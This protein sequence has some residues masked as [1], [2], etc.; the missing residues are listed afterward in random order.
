MPT[1]R[2][3]Q[4]NQYDLKTDFRRESRQCPDLFFDNGLPKIYFYVLEDDSEKFNDYLI[5]YRQR[6][7]EDDFSWL[8]GQ[9]ISFRDYYYH[10]LDFCISC[11]RAEMVRKLSKYMHKDWF[12]FIELIDVF[13]SSDRRRTSNLDHAVV[14]LQQY[15]GVE[16]TRISIVLFN[17]KIIDYQLFEFPRYGYWVLNTLFNHSNKN[18]LDDCL[19]IL[20]KPDNIQ[21][22]GLKDELLSKVKNFAKEKELALLRSSQEL[23]TPDTLLSEVLGIVTQQS[24]LN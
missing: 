20:A 12:T 4:G 6:L 22:L 15:F 8:I 5:Q 21:R 23:S 17:L 14:I 24:E 13:K 11:R 9:S 7:G 3:F 18:Y 1:D 19:A 10:L 2:I 16:V